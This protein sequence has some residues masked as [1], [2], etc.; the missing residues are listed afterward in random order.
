MIAIELSE[1]G[2]PRDP[3]PLLEVKSVVHEAD[4]IIFS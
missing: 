3:M 4:L 1:R 2:N